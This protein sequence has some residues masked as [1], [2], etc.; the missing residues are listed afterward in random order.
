MLSK[1]ALQLWGITLCSG[2][3]PTKVATFYSVLQ[4]ANQPNIAAL[5]KD[6]PHNF[7]LM[8]LFATA[9]VNM[10]EPRLSKQLPE[11]PDGQ[12]KKIDELKEE[13]AENLFLDKV[14]GSESSLDRQTWEKNVLMQASWILDSNNVRKQ[15]YG[16]LD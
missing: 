2:D 6:F 11:H 1:K 4:D 13:F 12:F 8:V 14:F 3:N 7:Y 15:V 5:D 16:W 10:F 9:L